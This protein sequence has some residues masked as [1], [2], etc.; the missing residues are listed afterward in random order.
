MFTG[1]SLLDNL[2]TLFLQ[3]VKSQTGQLTF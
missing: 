1:F 3:S 2:L